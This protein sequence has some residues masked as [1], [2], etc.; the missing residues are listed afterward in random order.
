VLPVAAHLTGQYVINYLYVGVPVVI[1]AKGVEKVIEFP[2]D[3]GEKAMFEKSISAV[4]G[5][6]DACKKLDASLA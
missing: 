3:A 6:L 2:M 4:R 1:G 5:L